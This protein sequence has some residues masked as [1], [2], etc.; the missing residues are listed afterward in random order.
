V[1]GRLIEDCTKTLCRDEMAKEDDMRPCSGSKTSARLSRS[2]WFAIVLGGAAVVSLSAD[3]SFAVT[4][5]GVVE[6]QLRLLLGFW[7]NIGGPG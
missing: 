5:P 3:L 1:S 4:V 2:Q 7:R 6:T